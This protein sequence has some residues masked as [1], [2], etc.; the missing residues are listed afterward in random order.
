MWFDGLVLDWYSGA[1]GYDGG[2]LPLGRVV[3]IDAEGATLRVRALPARVQGSWE[4]SVQASS[5][6]A[7]ARWLDRSAELDLVCSPVTLWV[8]GNP[9]KFLQ[10]HNV[11]GPSVR[12][13]APV[14]RDMVRAFP[15]EMRPSNAD[16]DRW[17]MLHRTRVDL[18]VA[19]DLGSHGAVH[20]WLGDAARWSRSR[21][22]EA[23]LVRAG[24]LKSPTV[25][26]QKRSRRWTI[27]A[28]CKT[29]ELRAHRPAVSAEAEK[30]LRRYAEGLLRIEL[31][32]RTP[33]LKPLGTLHEELVWTYMRKLEVGLM[34]DN[35]EIAGAEE[36]SPRELGMLELWRR[37]GD[38]KPMAT[39]STYYRLR[40]RVLDVT[41]VDISF[42]P[43][44]VPGESVHLV[45][46]DELE[47]GQVS[48]IPDDLRELVHDPG[49]SPEWPG[50]S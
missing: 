48:E 49:P 50:P 25:Y 29:C 18:N 22:G 5:R 32:L 34:V 47:A 10:G 11:L 16:D 44:V 38:P 26:W 9:T 46:V 28:Y 33:E 35:G 15:A 1:T 27:K 40:R 20:S 30:Q 23:E 12:H 6:T 45:G 42:P 43:G 31:T 14:V 7:E 8:S 19:T 39:K 24:I 36:L 4:S 37:G 3:E 21:K 13:L 2:A 17:P 41:G